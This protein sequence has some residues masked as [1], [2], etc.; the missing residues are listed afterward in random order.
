[1]YGLRAGM[2]SVW[3][4]KVSIQG[5]QCGSPPISRIAINCGAMLFTYAELYGRGRL[6]PVVIFSV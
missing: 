6:A 4:R 2:A 5:V 3:S 1:M